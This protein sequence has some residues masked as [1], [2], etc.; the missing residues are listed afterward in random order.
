MRA[1][2][3]FLAIIGATLLAAALLAYP[4]YAALHPH[5]PGW[6]FDKVATRLWQ[7]LMLLALI[8][9]LN[10]LRLRRARD[11]GYG[12]PRPRWLRQFGAGL[13]AGLA[14]MVPVAALMLALGLRLVRPE[15]TLPELLRVLLAAA[16]SGLAVGFVEETFFRGLMLGA[17]LR[18]LRRP[19]SAIALIAVVYASVHFLASARIPPAAVNSL[20]GFTLLKAA[21]GNFLAP[22][23][24]ADAWLALFAVGLLL[25]ACA[26]WTGNI[27]LGVGLHASWVFVMRTTVGLTVDNAAA[28]HA[29]LI[30]PSNGFLGWLVLAWTLAITIGMLLVRNRFRHWHRTI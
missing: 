27:A 22:S 21:L 13:L 11:F 23:G 3:W 29:W 9:V 8:L 12:A 5:F 26:Y 24:I 1:F 6:W 30:N 25:G 10:H 19:L 28:A 16:L 2:L 14:T 15:L 7:L 20:S 17:V 18:E 4:L